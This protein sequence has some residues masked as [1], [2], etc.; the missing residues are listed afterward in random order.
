MRHRFRTAVWR[1]L[2]FSARRAILGTLR[3]LDDFDAIMAE[4]WLSLHY[5]PAWLFVTCSGTIGIGLTILLFVTLSQEMLNQSARGPQRV[6][7]IEA[8]ELHTR[9]IGE[10]DTRLCLETDPPPIRDYDAEFQFRGGML[11]DWPRTRPVSRQTPVAVID[12]Q[13]ELESVIHFQHAPRPQLPND[14][15]T[16]LSATSESAEPRLPTGR[17]GRD[18]WEWWRGESSPVVDTNPRA[19]L[20]DPVLNDTLEPEED[21]WADPTAWP[22]RSD[23]A[24]RIEL[25]APHE[26]PVRQAGRSH[27]VIKNTGEEPIRRIRLTEPAALLPFVT[28]AEPEA[29]LA[30]NLLEREFRRLRPGRDRILGLAWQPRSSGETRHEARVMAEVVVAANVFIEAPA[31]AMSIAPE[32][33]EEPL[34][35]EPPMEVIPEPETIPDPLFTPEPVVRRAP[36]QEPAPEPEPEPEPAPPPVRRPR[37]HPAVACTVKNNAAAYID[38]VVELKVV[39]QNTGDVALNHVRLWADVPESL[40]HQHGKKLEFSIGRLEPGQTQE[41]VFRAI[42]QQAGVVQTSFRVVAEETESASAEGKVV[43]SAPKPVAKPRPQPPR[44]VPPRPQPRL[45]PQPTC[46]CTCLTELSWAF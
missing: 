43:I 39:V 1:E 8:A 31:E 30:N 29:R 18:G 12:E 33:V 34:P 24:L 11:A 36:Q 20:G 23:V 41:A 17:P 14:P 42:G 22:T 44:P 13:P 2:P 9:R 10:L 15:P 6:A 4:F 7:I 32:V 16:T 40:I 5:S 19:Y 27:V 35:V 21:V 3:A 37:V 45:V 26:S 38:Q 46:P 28:G 25:H